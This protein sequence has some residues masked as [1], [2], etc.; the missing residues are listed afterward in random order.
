MT[1]AWSYEPSDLARIK[2]QAG[3]T[4]SV[5]LP[6]RNEERTIRSIVE[7]IRGELQESVGLVDE[8]I[9][10]D[11]GSVDATAQA[12]VCAGAM[13]IAV[14]DVLSEFGPGLGKGD[15]LWRSLAASTG[16]LVVWCDSDIVEFGAQFVYGLLGPMLTAECVEFVKGAFDRP[17]FGGMGG[18]RVTEL[19]A[20]PLL[21]LVRPDLGFIDQPLSGSYAGRRT[22]LEQLSF[23]TDFGVDV[24]L[25]L[26]VADLVGP[27]A[28]AQVHLGEF[29]HQHRPL[30]EL[31]GQAN[32]VA[33]AILSRYG[34]AG[35]GAS[36]VLRPPIAS[37]RRTEPA[38]A[39]VL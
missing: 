36:A 17:A 31:A 37:T 25:L 21:S 5:C 2:S 11:D 8:L 39:S 18:G 24:G 35:D 7:T 20:R 32:S 38:R 1:S 34:D 14:D 28:I 33:R 22:T 9:V 3:L 10:F 13:V 27:D 4:V 16:E 15:V 6:A 12:A 23:E 29:R 26:D 19:L 30:A